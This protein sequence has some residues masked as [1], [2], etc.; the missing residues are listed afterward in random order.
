MNTMRLLGALKDPKE[1]PGH[2]CPLGFDDFH[3]ER[4]RET[5]KQP[6]FNVVTVNA[7]RLNLQGNL[8]HNRA[9]RKLLGSTR[10][11]Q[12]KSNVI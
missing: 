10:K 6:Q 7:S 8:G 1:N 12:K 5:C 11:T 2:I 3:H 4:L 9:C